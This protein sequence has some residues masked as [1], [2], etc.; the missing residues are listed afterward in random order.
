MSPAIFVDVLYNSLVDKQ[1]LLG[2]LLKF[3]ALMSKTIWCAVDAQCFF[4]YGLF[5]CQ[6]ILNPM[7]KHHFD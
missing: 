1:L 6:C 7:K 3:S 5:N 2:F 4:F